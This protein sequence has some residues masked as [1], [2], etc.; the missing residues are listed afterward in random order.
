ME[1]A[2]QQMQRGESAKETSERLEE[3][4]CSR[5]VAVPNFCMK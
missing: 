4:V 5:R 1:K 3:R 2:G